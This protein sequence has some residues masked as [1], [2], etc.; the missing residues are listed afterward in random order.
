MSSK[1]PEDPVLRSS[2]REALMALGIWLAAMTYTVGFSIWQGYGHPPGQMPSLVL[3]I[4]SWVVFGVI[5]PWL[6]CIAAS[7][8]FAYGWMTDEPL[9]ADEDISDD[10]PEGFEDAL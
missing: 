5:A 1:L 3:G 2:R 6:V 8:W 9:G 10:V 7:W 4:P